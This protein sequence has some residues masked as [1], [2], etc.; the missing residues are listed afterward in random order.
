MVPRLRT[1]LLRTL[2]RYK[3]NSDARNRVKI[4]VVVPGDWAYIRHQS[5]KENKLNQSVKVLLQILHRVGHYVIVQTHTELQRISLKDVTPSLV[6]GQQ[7]KVRT[8]FVHPS[9][10]ATRPAPVGPAGI[11]YQVDAIIGDAYPDDPDG[12]CVIRLVG[13]LRITPV[14]TRL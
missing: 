9:V 12:F 11:E 8:N 14:G 7:E 10:A 5:F 6:P 1:A 3:Q 2:L 4:I 13:G